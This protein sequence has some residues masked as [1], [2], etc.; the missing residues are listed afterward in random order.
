ME[1]KSNDLPDLQPDPSK[2]KE[3]PKAS[4]LFWL[5]TSEPA[6]LGHCRRRCPQVVSYVESEP[7]GEQGS[8]REKVSTYTRTEYP[9]TW[10]TDWCGEYSR[11]AR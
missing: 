1:T 11:Q 3:L 4:C 10:A 9:D 6:K 5:R 7:H 8:Y 2:V